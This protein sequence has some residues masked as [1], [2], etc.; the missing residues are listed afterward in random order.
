MFKRCLNYALKVG[1]LNLFVPLRFGFFWLR[2][3]NISVP[4]DPFFQLISIMFCDRPNQ[5]T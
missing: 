2:I 3:F 5:V 1:K 4:L